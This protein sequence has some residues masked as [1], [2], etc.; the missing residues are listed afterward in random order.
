MKDQVL[1][2]I[3][4]RINLYVRNKDKFYEQSREISRPPMERDELYLFSKIEEGKANVMCELNI[5][6]ERSV[7]EDDLFEIIED[8][9]KIVGDYARGYISEARKEMFSPAERDESYRRSQIYYYGDRDWETNHL[10]RPTS[11]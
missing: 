11:L 9:L 6:I 4:R 10:L 3:D 1:N 2:E 8:Y 5:L 7:E